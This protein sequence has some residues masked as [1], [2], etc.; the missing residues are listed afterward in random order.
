[1]AEGCTDESLQFYSSWWLG[2]LVELVQLQL[3][4][5]PRQWDTDKDKRLQQ[6]ISPEWRAFMPT[7]TWKHS[8]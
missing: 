8:G 7:I 3:Y 2:K 1:M 6:S 4:N 5:W